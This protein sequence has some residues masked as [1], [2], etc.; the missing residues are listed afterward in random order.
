VIEALPQHAR[1]L[2]FLEVDSEADIQA[3]A[4]PAGVE[5]R[6]LFRRGMPAGGSDVLIDAVRNSEWLDGRVQVFAHG[7]RGYMKALRDVFYAQ[8]GLERGQVSL[9]GYWAKGRVEDD[10]QAEK[11]LPVGQI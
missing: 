11:K 9:S 2:A 1:G 4:A 3:V 10:F 5:L 6:W 7:E 8:R